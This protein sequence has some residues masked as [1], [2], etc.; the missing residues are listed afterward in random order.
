MAII[1]VVVCLAQIAAAFHFPMTVQKHTSLIPNRWASHT[2]VEK[3][4]CFEFST[5]STPKLLTLVP[6]HKPKDGDLHNMR[7]NNPTMMCVYVAPLND[8]DV[9]DAGKELSVLKKVIAKLENRASWLS[10][11]KHWLIQATEAAA[12]VR[13]QIV[14][15]ENAK[16]SV[17]RD[18]EQ[19]QMAQNFLSV[20]LKTNQLKWSFK[21]KKMT[22]DKLR[23]KLEQLHYVKTDTVHA[24]RGMRDDIKVLETALGIPSRQVHIS[25]SEIDS[26]LKFLE[27]VQ[28]EENFNV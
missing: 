4:R 14:S 27:N 23:K 28:P 9:T 2:S 22:F 24:I 8:L 11:Q 16:V 21:D 26:P 20:R 13:S 12:T 18:L 1:I 10:A 3:S 17:V 19:L 5:H 25:S 15:T 6:V 7:D